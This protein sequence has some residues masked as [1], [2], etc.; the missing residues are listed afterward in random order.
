MLKHRFG[1]SVDRCQFFF[2]FKNAEDP[3]GGARARGG[4]AKTQHSAPSA[5]GVIAQL[6]HSGKSENRAQ[7][8]QLEIRAERALGSKFELSA[9]SARISS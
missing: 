4:I 6:Q 8:A 2:P 7:R 9:R 1:T 3:H 5:R